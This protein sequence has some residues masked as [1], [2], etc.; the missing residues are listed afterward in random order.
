MYNRL[1]TQ[2]Q[3]KR[4]ENCSVNFICCVLQRE[5]KQI[6]REW[7]RLSALVNRF[8]LMVYSF[9]MLVM[10]YS[11]FAIEREEL[12]VDESQ[13]QKVTSADKLIEEI[14]RSVWF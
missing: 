8:L 9:C 11:I 6:R 7:Q 5:Q 12:G 4:H 2:M 3:P 14:G 13:L 10:W 1:L